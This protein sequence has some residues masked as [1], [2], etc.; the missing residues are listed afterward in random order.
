[1]D[2]ISDD[3]LPKF[4]AISEVNGR[5]GNVTDRLPMQ[6][7]ILTK[8]FGNGI[9]CI[10]NLPKET[11]IGTAQVLIQMSKHPEAENRAAECD[12]LS[13]CICKRFVPEQL[14]CQRILLTGNDVNCLSRRS[15]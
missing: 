6:D 8:A 5:Y 1:M 11:T 10:E 3:G 13:F 14:T 9:I 4:S 15:N 2:T 12:C 7:E